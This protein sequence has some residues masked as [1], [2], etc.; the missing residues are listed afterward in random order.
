[1]N[2]ADLASSY[3]AVQ[4]IQSL[5]LR[6]LEWGESDVSPQNGFGQSYVDDR[7]FRKRLKV[8]RKQ[9]ILFRKPNAEEDKHFDQHMIFGQYG[10]F[11]VAIAEHEGETLVIRERIWNG[12]PDP[13]QFVFFALQGKE[14]TCAADFNFWPGKWVSPETPPERA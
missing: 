6:Y 12:W 14:V 2:D 11:N 10:D 3:G 9:R 1:M 8:L 13:P 7:R 4:V 5:I